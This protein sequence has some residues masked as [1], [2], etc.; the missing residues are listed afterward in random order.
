MLCLILRCTYEEDLIIQGAT[1]K[2]IKMPMISNVRTG[3]LGLDN[4]I[5]A[6]TDGMG[7]SL[8]LMVAYNMMANGPSILSFLI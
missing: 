8:N 5:L 1:V 3:Y 6:E 2:R 4:K 7:G